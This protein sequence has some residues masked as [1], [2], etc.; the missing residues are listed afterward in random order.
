MAKSIYAYEFARAYGPVGYL[1]ECN[2]TDATTYH[3]I[4]VKSE[5]L[6]HKRLP[7]EPYLQHF[8]EELNEDILIWA[9]V[10]LF[11]MSDISQLYR[12]SSPVLKRDIAAYYGLH[13][14][15][16]AKILEIFLYSMT[17]LRNECAHGER[18]FNRLFARKP[19]LNRHDRLL[20]INNAEK[21]EDNA[22]LYGYILTMKRMLLPKE[23]SKLKT[24]IVSL[25]DKYPF[26][27]MR[28]YGFRDDWKCAI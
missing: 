9:Y 15:K 16:S 1:D 26:V 4:L 6:M 21:G 28:Y 27:D 18:L 3:K 10:D 5:E 19:S 25:T 22:H 11:T 8:R 2:F 17:I 7:N 13:T 20:L 23:W 24:E 14:N 12:I